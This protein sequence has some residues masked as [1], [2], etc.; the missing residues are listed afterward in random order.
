MD[1]IFY[2]LL[3]SRRCRTASHGW[4]GRKRTHGTCLASSNGT[5]ASVGIGLFCLAT[6]ACGGGGGGDS[7]GVPAGTVTLSGTAAGGAP[8]IGTITVKDSTNFER[9]K[10]IDLAAA[11]QYSIDV[12]GLK[13]PFLLRAEGT[14][15]GT[16]VTYFSGATSD[17]LGKTI[18]I[19]PFTDLIIGNIAGQLAKD[20]YKSP[21]FAM[22]TTGKLNEERDR[23]KG[24]LTDVLKGLGV[25][26]SVDLLRSSFK[27]DHTGLDQVL[28]IVRVTPPGQG[29]GTIAK[30]K[31]LANEQEIEDDLASHETTPLPAIN[32]TKETASNLQQITDL[33]K[34]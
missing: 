4:T 13:P 19:T 1:S 3:A 27:A 24:R 33:G 25:D 22:L 30:I 29:Q 20:F 32:T 23:L 26:D 12:T 2:S 9:A 14:I 15:G 11:G 34:A 7:G 16:S 18:N 21:N 17:D 10:T 8:L 6:T 31:N 28:D 5:F